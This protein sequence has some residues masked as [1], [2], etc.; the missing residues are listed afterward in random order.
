MGRDPKIVTL[1]V[2]PDKSLSHR[3][4]YLSLLSR[5]IS[6]LTNLSPAQDVWRTLRVIQKLGVK[7]EGRPPG[8]LRVRGRGKRLVEPKTPLYGG[9]S[10]TTVRLG[11]GVTA[12]LS[13]TTFWY[14]DA[15]L[16]RRPMDRVLQPLGRRGVQWMARKDRFLPVSM[17]GGSLSAYEGY[18]P[19][20]SAQVK[21]ALLLSGLWAHGPTVV[22]EAAPSRDHTERLLEFLG[23]PIYVDDGKIRMDPIPEA[24]PPLR[25]KLPGDPSSAAFFATWAL[26]RKVPLRVEGLLLNPRR[27]RFFT[28]LK[29][30][31]VP[32]QT[33]VWEEEPEPIGV[34]SIYSPE[35]PW[36]PFNPSSW[37]IPQI[38]DEIFLLALLA[39]QADGISRFQGIGELRVKESDRLIMTYRIL[40]AVGVEIAIQD[41][42]WEVQGPRPLHPPGGWIATT[43]HRMVMLQAILWALWGKI[44]PSSRLRA[45]S[46]SDPWFESNLKKCVHSLES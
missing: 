42:S 46:I 34:L 1:H 20:A 8:P 15:S 4:L 36:R 40:R 32:V 6:S 39:S 26:L 27:I 5:G 35:A 28:L 13:G 18:I 21:S 17:R 7:I 31:G 16:H 2:V 38:I 3:V 30:A 44:P 9:N 10:G 12:L 25:I 24:L 41:D 33:D 37:E 19:I 14:G 45:A 22:E 29:N 43:D 23:I 11:M